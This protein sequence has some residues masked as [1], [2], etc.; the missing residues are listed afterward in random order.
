MGEYKFNLY[1][2]KKK[3]L[4]IMIL[5]LFIKL[6]I[7]SFIHSNVYIYGSLTVVYTILL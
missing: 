6:T 7:R 2:L 1:S 5:I 3:F 4:C